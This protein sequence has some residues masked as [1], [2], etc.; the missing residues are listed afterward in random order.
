M[1][2]DSSGNRYEEIDIPGGHVRVTYIKEGWAE[3]PSVRIQIRDNSGHLRQGPEVPIDRVGAVLGA[4]VN[5]L[6]D[7]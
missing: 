3:N 2:C 5:L 1:E 4:V 7:E 6:A